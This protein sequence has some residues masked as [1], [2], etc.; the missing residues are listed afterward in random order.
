M[1]LSILLFMQLVLLLPVVLSPSQTL[2]QPAKITVD[3]PV[4]LKQ[5]KVVFNMDHTAFAGDTP[6][7][8]KHMDLMSA[9]FKQNKVDGKIIGI[10]HG[11]AGY[12]LLGDAKYNEVRKT[13]T[14]NPYKALVTELQQQDVAIE[15]CMVTLRANKWGNADLLPNVKVNSGALG[16]IIELVQGG[17]VVIQP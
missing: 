4:E 7:G 14:G 5:A 16:R 11:D 1:R 15:V 3:I 8:M 12:M 13:K 17:F 10:F 9:S 6:V 2:A